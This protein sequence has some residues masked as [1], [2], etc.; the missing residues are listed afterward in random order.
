MS[1]N[2]RQ[3]NGV[4]G[5][6]GD[7]TSKPSKKQAKHDSGAA[8]L[9]KV[10]DYVEESEVNTENMAEAVNLIGVRRSQETAEREKRRKELDKVTI[11]KED[12]ELIMNEMEIPKT[13]AELT[14]RE[15]NGDIVKAL[16]A[17]TN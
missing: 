13:Q 12:V 9:E 3:V 4:Q 17:L 1:P 8:D 7:T 16:T 2:D 10:T 5:E 14:L 11:R 6:E 15:N